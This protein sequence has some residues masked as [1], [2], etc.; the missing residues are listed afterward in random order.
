[1]NIFLWICYFMETF[2][3]PGFLPTNTVEYEDELHELFIECRKLRSRCNLPFEGPEMLPLHVQAL[4]RSIKI[5][6]RRLGS[7]CHTCGCVKPIRA[8]HCGLCNRCVRVMDHHCPV[9][10]NCVGEDNRVWFLLTS[11]MVSGVSTWIGYL[12]VKYW[13]QVESTS[14]WEVITLCLLV[15]G[16]LMAINA[17]LMTVSCPMS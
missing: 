8:K 14:L 17:V 9:T 16:W 11:V 2:K 6:K 10:D 1:M 5:L 12:T 7:L 3:D 13:K 15:V 4:R